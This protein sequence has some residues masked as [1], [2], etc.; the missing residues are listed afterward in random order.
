MFCRF[1]GKEIENDSLF[2]RHCGQSLGEEG[3]FARFLRSIEKRV[4]TQNTSSF[5]DKQQH[6]CYIVISKDQLSISIVDDDANSIDFYDCYAIIALLRYDCYNGFG[7]HYNYFFNL[8]FFDEKLNP[9]SK[10]VVDG[11]TINKV[12]SVNNT[13]AW[14]YIEAKDR[15]DKTRYL[16]V[17][18]GTRYREDTK[19]IKWENS[20]YQIPSY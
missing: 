9:I 1:C 2:C 20:I 8:G 3:N 17:F 19:L 15:Y 5:G 10:L 7:F 4:A 11:Y 12:D 6:L 18:K 16:N 13:F 14:G